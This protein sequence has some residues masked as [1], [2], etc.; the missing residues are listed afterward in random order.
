[1]EKRIWKHELPLD[2]CMAQGRSVPVVVPRGAILLDIGVT[3][4]NA[5][6]WEIHPVE[7]EQEFQTTWRFH[8]VPTGAIFNVG[9]H[10]N[11][12]GH[13]KI[14]NWFIVHVYRDEEER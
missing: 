3:E 9:E 2:A 12:L 11:Y 13:L 14:Q 8:L 6:F 5:V 1:M 7:S 10:Y 4:D